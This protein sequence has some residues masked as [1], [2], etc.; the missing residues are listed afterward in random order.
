MSA[1]VYGC[2]KSFDSRAALVD[3]MQTEHVRRRP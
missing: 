3:H 1:F 2:G